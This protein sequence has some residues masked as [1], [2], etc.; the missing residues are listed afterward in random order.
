M[1]KIYAKHNLIPCRFLTAKKPVGGRKQGTGST[2]ECLPCA[3]DSSSEKGLLLEEVFRDLPQDP[4]EEL[5]MS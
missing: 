1:P 5:T 2:A 3:E 4:T